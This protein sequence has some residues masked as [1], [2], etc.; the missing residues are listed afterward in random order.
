MHS[1]VL[2]IWYHYILFN[3]TYYYECSSFTTANQRN[4]DAHSYAAIRKFITDL[5]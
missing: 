3:Y 1:F 4:N 2:Y 5:N